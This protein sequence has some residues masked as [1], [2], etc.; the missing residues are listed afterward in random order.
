[1]GAAKKNE[2]FDR[3]AI[4]PERGLHVGLWSGKGHKRN[5]LQLPR[6]KRPILAGERELRKEVDNEG[7][8]PLRR[9]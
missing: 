3:R 9:T 2:K 5:N 1:M 4:R 6:K 7:S 8:R